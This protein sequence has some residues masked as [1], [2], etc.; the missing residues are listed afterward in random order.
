MMILFI[1]WRL[2]G[3]NSELDSFCCSWASCSFGH[4]RNDTIVILELWFYANQKISGYP[5]PNSRAWL[6][7]DV[8]F[9]IPI[10]RAFWVFGDFPLSMAM[11]HR[12]IHFLAWWW[13]WFRSFLQQKQSQHV[14]DN[15]YRSMEWIQNNGH[16]YLLYMLE[17]PPYFVSNDWQ[18]YASIIWRHKDR[19][20]VVPSD[21]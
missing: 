5:H 6:A 11:L 12:V 17:Q 3:F 7:T 21:N 2:H 15:G 19:K 4:R 1:V 20:S 10:R 18:Q 9:T 8:L 13:V 14:N 16:K